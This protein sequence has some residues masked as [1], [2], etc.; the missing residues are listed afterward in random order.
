MLATRLLQS[1]KL[2]VV[3]CLYRRDKKRLNLLLLI[4]INQLRNPWDVIE[5]FCGQI[6]FVVW[7]IVMGHLQGYYLAQKE[8]KDNDS[9][10]SL[11]LENK[12]S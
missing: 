10:A 4:L 5:I 11:N 3:K 7:L 12:L 8:G 2:N 1:I 9:T 6:L